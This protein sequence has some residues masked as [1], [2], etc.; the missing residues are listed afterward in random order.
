MSFSFPFAAVL[1]RHADPG[2]E[3][4]L[5]VHT[6]TCATFPRAG[7]NWD[8][9]LDLLPRAGVMDFL[10]GRPELATA[11]PARRNST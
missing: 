5:E 4:D 9:A 3:R 6:G 2:G 7:Q 8:T 10:T 11:R 1:A